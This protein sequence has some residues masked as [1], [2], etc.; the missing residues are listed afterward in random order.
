MKDPFRQR[1]AKF[2]SF[3]GIDGCG[4]STLLNDLAAWLKGWQGKYPK[5][6]AWVEDNIGETLSYYSLPHGHHKHLKSTNMLERL[7][8]EI[9]RRTRVVRIFPNEQSCL[10]LIRALAVETH[11]NWI[12]AH[13]YLD[14]NLLHEHKKE[15]LMQLAA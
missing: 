13:R 2:V 5:L 9:K 8:E 1:S 10:R 15:L 14:M 7:N 3:E 6:C 11:E 12:E 4:K